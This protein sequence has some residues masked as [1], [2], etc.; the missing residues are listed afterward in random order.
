MKKM[1]GLKIGALV[2]TG[3]LMFA[4]SEADTIEV[5]EVLEEIVEETE[6]DFSQADNSM[7]SLDWPGIYFGTLPCADCEGIETTITIGEDGSYTK[8]MEYL[9]NKDGEKV[10][11]DEGMIQWDELGAD[12]TLIS[13][14]DVSDTPEMYKVGENRL[15]ALDING[16]RITGDLEEFYILEKQD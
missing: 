3:A 1:K 4:C 13:S 8:K 10:F 14:L 7:T 9:T 5:E 6:I 16:E 11:T 15:F 12:I 2:L